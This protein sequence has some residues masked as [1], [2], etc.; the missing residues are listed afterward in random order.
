MKL[1][2]HL[3]ERG[4]QIGAPFAIAVLEQ[5]LSVRSRPFS[6]PRKAGRVDKV[7]WRDALRQ[8]LRHLGDAGVG[9][10]SGLGA[11]AGFLTASFASLA[12]GFGFGLAGTGLTA[13]GGGVSTPGGA[14]ETCAIA[15]PAR[16]HREPARKDGKIDLKRRMFIPALS[17]LRADC[18][19]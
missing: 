16:H 1:V 5:M 15:V 14:S 8:K 17:L 13:S 9:V 18:R 10:A 12:T 4:D 2:L 7:A 19:G 6:W 11:V 3:D